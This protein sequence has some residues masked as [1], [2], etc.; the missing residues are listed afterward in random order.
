MREE[1]FNELALLTRQKE[2]RFAGVDRFFNELLD[3]AGALIGQGLGLVKDVGRTYL[4][5]ITW[6]LQTI[7]GAVTNTTNIPILPPEFDAV[8]PITNSKVQEQF[9]GS[10]RS[11]QVV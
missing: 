9:G 11:T 2:G 7:D 10:I 4:E 1:E 8:S 3:R 5:C 6:P